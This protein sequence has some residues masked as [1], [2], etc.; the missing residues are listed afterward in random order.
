MD[1]LIK[2]NLKQGWEAWKQHFDAHSTVRSAACDESRT[3]A[4]RVDESQALVLVYDAK[5]DV[6]GAMF[7]S[8]EFQQ[9][10]EPFVESH[11]VFVVEPLPAP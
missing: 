7:S 1:L 10:T 2:L 8:A 5:M 4:V 9:L 3:V 11:E 6:M